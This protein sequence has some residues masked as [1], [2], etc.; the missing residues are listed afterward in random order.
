MQE[1][2][3]YDQAIVDFDQAIRLGPKCA[4]A[5]VARGD[6]WRSKGHLDKAFAD[7]REV[8]RLDPCRSSIANYSDNVNKSEPANDSDD[9]KDAWKYVARGNAWHNQTEYDQAIAAFD[10]AVRPR[11]RLRAQCLRQSERLLV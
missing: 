4:G 11:P 7:Y 8:T 3:Q 9:A 5:H 1:K 2:E 10:E 6:A